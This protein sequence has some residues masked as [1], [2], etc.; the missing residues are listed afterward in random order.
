[1]AE[2]TSVGSVSISLDLDVSSKLEKQVQDAA[3]KV[4]Q[5]F[6]DKF[7]N[8]ANSN[9]FSQSFSKSMEQSF[10]KLEKSLDSLV[11]KASEIGAKIGKRISQEVSDSAADVDV[12]KPNVRTSGAPT[13]AGPKVS[14]TISKEDL[15]QRRGDMAA[16]QDNINAQIDVIRAKMLEMTRFDPSQSMSPSFMKLEGQMLSLASKSNALTVDINNLD[17]SIANFDADKA[18]AEQAKLGKE[19]EAAS[20]ATRRQILDSERLTQTQNRTAASNERLKQAQMRTKQM[21]DKISQSASRNTKSITKMGGSTKNSTKPLI[22]M[23]SVGASLARNLLGLQLM[24]SLV[25]QGV[26][27]MAQGFV[28]SLKTNKQF[29]SSLDQIKSNLATAFQPIFQ[30]ILPAVNAMMS[31]ISKATAYLAGFVS[32][33]FGKSVSASNESAKAMSQAAAGVNEY[34]SAV[35]NAQKITAGFDQ[36]NDITEDSGSGSGSG[37]K[38]QI[39]PVN[40]D[41]AELT[42]IKSFMDKVKSIVEQTFN[43]SPV[44]AFTNLV[45]TYFTQMYASI[46]RIGG[47]IGSNLVSIWQAMLPNIS[48]ALSN[49][50]VLWTTVFNDLAL[51]VTTWVPLMTEQIVL[52]IDNIFQT[53]EPFFV[54]ISKMW[55]DWTGTI[56]ELWNKYGQRILDGIGEFITGV[57][58]TFNKIWTHI[59]DPIVKPAI[60]FLS[61]IWEN[62]LKDIIFQIGDFIG[63]AIARG[64]ELYNKFIKPIIDWL[65]I[66]LGPAFTTV[67]NLIGGTVGG[68]MKGMLITVSEIIGSIR[69]IFDGLMTFLE[70]VFTGDWGKVWQ[71]MSDIFGGI[72]D[73]LKAIFKAPIN[74][75]IEGINGFIRG[76]N[77]VKIPDWVPGIGGKGFNIQPLVPL[78]NGGVLTQP[79]PMLGGE[80]SGARSNPEIVTP[81]NIMKDTFREV[82]AEFMSAFMNGL[83]MGG[84]SQGSINLVVNIGGMKLLEMIIDLAKEYTRQTGK[85]V[86]INA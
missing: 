31:A 58:D 1:M 65:V 37:A 83:G 16:I 44:K 71:G 18:A 55:A 50:S 10:S 42:G 75:I 35:E 40:I 86:I 34:G 74:W 76:L 80:Y 72:F 81:Q 57:M 53:F 23:R 68:V 38:N 52:L 47:A 17:L 32:M 64:L 46:V 8:S 77:K 3:D 9:D 6:S 19:T 66:N 26:R 63:N 59:I 29:S 14:S 30:A 22:N 7:S 5:K 25:G 78:A 15:V 84:V 41:D 36:L 4:G 56:L 73:G 27:K 33:L 11:K 2:N 48:V 85:Q 28:N 49:I 20:K 54:L 12:K 60:E 67:F 45:V 82:M 62:H 24:I 69:K 61:D 21:M 39:S 70:G 79:T 13:R 51:Y 43:A